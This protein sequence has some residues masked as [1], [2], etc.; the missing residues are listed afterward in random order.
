[1]TEIDS[2]ELIDTTEN[3]PKIELEESGGQ[4]AEAFHETSHDNEQSP[5]KMNIEAKSVSKLTEEEKN[6]LINLYKNGGEDEHFKVTFCKNGSNRIAKKK[7]QKEQLSTKLIGNENK[8]PVQNSVSNRSLTN[9]QLLMEHVIDL[10]AKFATLQQ[11]HKKLK[12]YYKS[13]HEDIYAEDND[14]ANEVQPI[15][16]EAFHEAEHENELQNNQSESNYINR[17]KRQPKGYRKK[18]LN[19]NGF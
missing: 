15:Q 19:Q 7:Q 9:E 11:K 12:K 10:E 5:T 13:I 3:K 4:Q 14:L 17:I 8:K 2:V 18:M 6:Y 1:M 16:T